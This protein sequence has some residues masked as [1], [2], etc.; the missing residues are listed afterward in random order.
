MNN[1]IKER[2]MK[3]WKILYRDEQEPIILRFQEFCRSHAYNR[4]AGLHTLL[5]YADYAKQL[6]MLTERIQDNAKEITLLKE[7][8]SEPRET[9]ESKPKTMGSG[10]TRVK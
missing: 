7:M 8:L 4:V 1:P 9:V 2:W 10:I 3:E 5:E 6:T